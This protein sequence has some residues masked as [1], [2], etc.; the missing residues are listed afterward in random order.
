MFA[1]AEENQNK[2]WKMVAEK[3]IKTGD[4]YHLYPAHYLVDL[5]NG[6]NYLVRK[7]SNLYSTEYPA[8]RVTG[9]F[10]CQ[11]SVILLEDIV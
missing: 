4:I 5:R 3:Y 6:F 7:G 1:L 9:T 11:I 2:M 8:V 10:G